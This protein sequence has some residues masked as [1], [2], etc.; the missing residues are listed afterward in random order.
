LLV[1]GEVVGFDQ[2]QC[3]EVSGRHEERRLVSQLCPV[4]V[5]SMA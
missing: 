5:R 3:Q 2:G 1:L 4:Q